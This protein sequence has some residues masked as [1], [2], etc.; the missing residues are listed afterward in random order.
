[1]QSSKKEGEGG[2]RAPCS[3]PILLVGLWRLRSRQN[4]GA[5]VGRCRRN[6]EHT[7]E[8]GNSEWGKKEKG[9]KNIRGKKPHEPGKVMHCKKSQTVGAAKDG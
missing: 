9:E 7:E 1:L 2:E 6:S 5:R 3:K 4:A 8:G